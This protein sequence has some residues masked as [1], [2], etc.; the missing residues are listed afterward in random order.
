MGHE[1][2]LT[3]RR[4]TNCF[5]STDPENISATVTNIAK[6]PSGWCLNPLI[7]ERIVAFEMGESQCVQGMLLILINLCF[8]LLQWSV[9]IFLD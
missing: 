5:V 4:K 7:D 8:K 3:Y 6:K 2:I 9:F 1:D